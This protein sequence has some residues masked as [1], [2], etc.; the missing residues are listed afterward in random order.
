MDAM[1]DD[2]H[3]KLLPIVQVHDA[4]EYFFHLETVSWLLH[5]NT[6][7]N[8]IKS[9]ADFHLSWSFFPSVR[10]S[11]LFKKKKKKITPSVRADAVKGARQ[12]VCA[13]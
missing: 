11:C 6:H 3:F 10:Q 1:I 7:A 12:G 13:N 5:S 2:V 8:K 9:T 4:T